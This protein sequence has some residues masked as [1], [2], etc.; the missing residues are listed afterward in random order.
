LEEN[1]IWFINLSFKMIKY[2]K[3]LHFHY[4]QNKDNLYK[5]K[6]NYYLK[7]NLLKIITLIIISIALFFLKNKPIK[8]I[9][10]K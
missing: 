10:K 9:C 4:F 5:I 6:F 8:K 1:L 7:K 3:Y 2:H